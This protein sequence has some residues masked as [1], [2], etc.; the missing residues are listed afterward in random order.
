MIAGI[1]EVGNIDEA[2]SCDVEKF[3]LY[4][5]KDCTSNDSKMKYP[6]LVC[7]L[8]LILSLSHGNSAHE[9]GFS[10]NKLLLE[11][12]GSSP[13]EETIEAIGIF[14]DSILKYESIL[15]IPRTKEM[16]S[17]VS[18]SRQF[19]MDHLEQMQKEEKGFHSEAKCRV[20][21]Y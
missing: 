4:L 6:S 2:K 10:I 11:I 3:V 16:I 13:K 15:D 18:N 21:K 20:S 5:E 9:N 19:Y 8:K 17:M 1:T 12:H 14:K 7:L